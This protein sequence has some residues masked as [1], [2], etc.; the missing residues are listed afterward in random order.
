MGELREATAKNEA[1]ASTANNLGQESVVTGASRNLD[2]ARTSRSNQIGDSTYGQS[3]NSRRNA[4]GLN[5]SSILPE[6]PSLLEH[7][8]SS[9]IKGD[10]Q[11]SSGARS[12][13]YWTEDNPFR[14]SLKTSR[15]SA[16]FPGSEFIKC[17]RRG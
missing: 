16:M 12:S 15:R 14:A 7:R 17:N 8:R 6:H 11:E 9:R 3:N 4:K 13:T 10:A 1:T 5:P 2:D